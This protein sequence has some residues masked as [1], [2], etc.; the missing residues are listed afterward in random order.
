MK[1]LFKINLLLAFSLLVACGEGGS[2]SPE[3][4]SYTN[5]NEC[6]Y[7]NN[8]NIGIQGNSACPYQGAYDPNLGY[9]GIA[10][11]AKAGFNFEM[12]VGFN[13]DFGW[14]NQWEALCP[15]PGEVPVFMYD[16]FSHCI[17]AN[18][19]YGRSD[20]GINT[21]SCTGSQFNPQVTGCTPTG[22]RPRGGD[23]Y[24]YIGN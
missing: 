23:G 22:I 18:P 20:D 1:T 4:N 11:Q 13:I 14:N 15:Y 8:L 24:Y 12:G 7:N 6:Q 5:F 21:S 17:N 2:S 16:S 3:P 9:Q 10:I 19:T